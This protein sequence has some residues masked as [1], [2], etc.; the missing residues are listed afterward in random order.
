MDETIENVSST[1]LRVTVY[2]RL[3]DFATILFPAEMEKKASRI[4]VVF[5]VFWNKCHANCFSFWNGGGHSFT[6]TTSLKTAVSKD[7][8]FSSIMFFKP[9]KR[10]FAILIK[11]IVIQMMVTQ[12]RVTFKL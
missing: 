5:N 11:Q 3:T 8:Q 12:T 7:R 4:F 6:T 2:K 1:K 10:A 9:R